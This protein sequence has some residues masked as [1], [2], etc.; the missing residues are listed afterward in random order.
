MSAFTNIYPPY[1]YLIGWSEHNLWYY[2]VRYAN[3]TIPENDLWVKYF[4]SSKYVKDI[5]K[6]FGEPDV[7]QIR[8]KFDCPNKALAWEKR[9][10]SKLNVLTESKWI[11]R[12]I[13]GSLFVLPLNGEDNPMYGKNHS[14]ETKKLMSEKLKGRI[15]WNKGKT[16]SE[17][18]KQKM[19]EKAKTR[20]NKNGMLGKT[21]TEETKKK[22]SEMNS[23]ENYSRFSG[24]YI[25]PWGKFS[26]ASDA[27]KNSPVEFSSW[28]IN[29][30]C[31]K[32]NNKKVHQN[33][34][35]LSS[36]LTKNDIGKTF[37]ELGFGFEPL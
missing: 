21:H 23:G 24:Y 3:S 25:T 14:E 28:T 33:G 31:R 27:V 35:N 36:Y 6:E 1:T 10:L 4:S 2:G 19:S 9:V 12:N 7:I 22:L 16:H 17:E 11:N 18:S 32:D 15:P 34:V 8:K 37:N 26:S 20:T 5:R 30:W 29:R 13:G